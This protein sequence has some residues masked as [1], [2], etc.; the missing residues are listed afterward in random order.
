MLGLPNLISLLLLV[1]AV[2]FAAHGIVALA[3]EDA[4]MFEVPNP[5]PMPPPRPD[6]PDPAP[7]S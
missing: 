4:D 5:E 1:G 7:P 6:D 3:T 2:G